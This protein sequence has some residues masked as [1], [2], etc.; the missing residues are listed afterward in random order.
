LR[1]SSGKKLLYGG[2]GWQRQVALKGLRSN[3]ILFQ[4]A[5]AQQTDSIATA[6]MA[7]LEAMRTMLKIPCYLIFLQDLP[8]NPPYSRLC[9]QTKN[10]I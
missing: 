3:K 1:S 4:Y 7:I 9:C 5:T 8:K 10:N 6:K 2:C